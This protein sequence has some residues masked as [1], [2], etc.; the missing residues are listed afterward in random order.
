[1]PAACGSNELTLKEAPIITVVGKAFF[2]LGHAP[3]DQ[4][5][6]R[7]YQRGCAGGSSSGDEADVQ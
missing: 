1:M 4:S 2:D 7:S 6:W 5:N 3:K